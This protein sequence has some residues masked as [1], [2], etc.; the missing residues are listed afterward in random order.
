VGDAA[1]RSLAPIPTDL[2]VGHSTEALV[3]GVTQHAPLA[4]LLAHLAEAQ[5]EVALAR[6][7]KRP[8]WSAELSYQKRG[9][10]FSDMVSLEFRVG[11]PLFSTHRQNPVIA[12]KLALVRAQEA[13]RDAEIR[14]HTAEVRAAVAEWK[15]S[16]ARL[17]HYTSEL[18]PLSH[19]RARA[20]LAGYSAARTDLHSAIEALSEEIDTELEY[21]ELEG[22]VARVWTFLHFLHDSGASP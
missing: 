17:D 18:L 2:D 14:M 21:V 16:R 15:H 4:P 10:E 1:E 9:S 3:A 19:E 8:D 6:A 22:S 7:E 13:E 5:T 11:L 20:A 12:E